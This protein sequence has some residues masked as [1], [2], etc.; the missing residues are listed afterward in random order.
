MA[1]VLARRSGRRPSLILPNDGYIDNISR[2]AVVEVPGL[3]E[4]GAVRGLAVG[5]L[6]APIAQM[7][8]REVEIQKLVVDAAVT[9][10]R[11]LALQ[12]LLIDPVVNSARKAEVLLDDILTAHAKHLPQ[13]AGR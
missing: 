2:D 3:V 9:G 6:P 11:E 1:D 13:F 5:A 7:V 10:S 4:E 8:Q 12:A